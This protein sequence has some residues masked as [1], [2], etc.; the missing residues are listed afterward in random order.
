MVKSKVGAEP[1]KRIK[2][3]FCQREGIHE[4][5]HRDEP[6]WFESNR[7]PYCFGYGYFFHRGSS[8]AEQLTP[9]YIKEHWDEAG[10]Y[11]SL[12][13]DGKCYTHK[14]IKRIEAMNL[15]YDEYNSL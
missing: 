8:L 1:K 9:E 6:G 3:I 12:K 4:G 5:I 14:D 2:H 10:W 13:K 11:G 15:E 7:H